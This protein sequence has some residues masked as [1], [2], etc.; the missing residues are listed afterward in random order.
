MVRFKLMK[1]L[2]SVKFKQILSVPVVFRFYD[3]AFALQ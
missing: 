3:I 1:E 2:F